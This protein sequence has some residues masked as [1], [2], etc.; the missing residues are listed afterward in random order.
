MSKACMQIQMFALAYI[1]QH[2]AILY[3][4]V[5]AKDFSLDPCIIHVL[6]TLATCSDQG[7][8]LTCN[9]TEGRVLQQQVLIAVSQF[10]FV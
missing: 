1:H 2:Q 9:A 4:I 7:K 10:V 3:R 6:L 5:S 8:Q